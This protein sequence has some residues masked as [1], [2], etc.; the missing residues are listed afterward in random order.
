MTGVLLALLIL[1][2]FVCCHLGAHVIYL[3]VRL[4]GHALALHDIADHDG[5]FEHCPMFFCS[6]A[7][8]TLARRS[9]FR[10]TTY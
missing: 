8:V 3:R 2:L 6:D 1:A 4:L 5:E 10:R 7:R 9:P